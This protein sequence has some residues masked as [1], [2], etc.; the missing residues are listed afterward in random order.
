[1]LEPYAGNSRSMTRWVTSRH[2]REV[3]STFDL[4]I[5]V[6][7]PRRERAT[8]AATRTMRSISAAL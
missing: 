8:S 1:V 4:S 3:S 5:E 7:R 2:R 6:S